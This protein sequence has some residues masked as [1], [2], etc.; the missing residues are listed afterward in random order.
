MFSGSTSPGNSTVL[1]GKIGRRVVVTAAAYGLPAAGRLRHPPPARRTR[2]PHPPAAP[3]RRTRPPHPPAG[4]AHWRLSSRVAPAA[5]VV[6][7]TQPSMI[8]A[9]AVHW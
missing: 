3:A 7:S 8:S 1:R 9:A 5:T 2:P 6:A 4:H